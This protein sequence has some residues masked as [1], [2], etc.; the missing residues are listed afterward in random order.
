MSPETNAHSHPHHAAL[1]KGFTLIELLVVIAI[2]AI[3]AAI[4]FPVFAQAREAARKVTCV[5]N[6]RQLGMGFMQYFQDYDEQFPWIRGNTAWPM[7][8]QPY[9]KS[10]AL[11]KCPNDRSINWTT[12]LPG[13]TALH[14]ST[15]VL[16]AYMAPGASTDAQGGNYP[17]IGS[18]Q[19]PANVIFLTEAPNNYAEAYFHAYQWNPPTDTKHWLTATD[20]PDDVATDQHHGGF[21]V[22]YLDGH[23]KWVKWT[24]VWWRDSA[25][26]P[27]LKGAFDPR[28]P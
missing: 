11:L 13:K 16:N 2:I 23:A 21:N 8:V 6:V 27:P 12:P 20:R 3:L 25:F 17:F 14:L 24:Q 7:T 10:Q 5:S 28:Q 26:N 18:I 22:A 15:Y 19:K 1:R 4:L 9:I